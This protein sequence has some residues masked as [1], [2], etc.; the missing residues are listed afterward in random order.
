ML[1]WNCKYMFPYVLCQCCEL[2]LCQLCSSFI[3]IC[4]ELQLFKIMTSIK[5]NCKQ[6]CF[7]L[8]FNICILF[9]AKA[10]KWHPH[11]YRPLI[12]Y[13]KEGR[14]L[15]N[16]RHYSLTKNRLKNDRILSAIALSIQ[17]NKIVSHNLQRWNC[18]FEVT[19]SLLFNI[20]KEIL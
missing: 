3:L 4:I 10:L 2:N 6:K 9:K 8:I 11:Y 17:P 13:V 15:W 14:T 20:C 18:I 16:G 7:D 12:C 19:V 1:T 5:T